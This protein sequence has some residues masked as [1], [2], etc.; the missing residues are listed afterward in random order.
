MNR[1]VVKLVLS[2]NVSID[3]M[4]ER[5]LKK[6]IPFKGHSSNSSLSAI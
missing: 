3:S 6:S 4:Y 1:A 5:G 2:S